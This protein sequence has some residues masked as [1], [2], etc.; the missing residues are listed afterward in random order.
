MIS[1]LLLAWGLLCDT[2]L[3]M[4]LHGPKAVY[5][6]Y[7][8]SQMRRQWD[9]RPPIWAL[10][11]DYRG[12]KSSEN[13]AGV[14][15]DL[16]I[17]VFKNAD[18]LAKLLQTLLDS[19]PLRAQRIIL[20][21]DC[22]NDPSVAHHLTDFLEQEQRAEVISQTSNLGFSGNVTALLTAS[23]ADYV[24]VLN[25]DTLIPPGSLDRLTSHFA[26]DPNLATISPLTNNG[27]YAL[28]ASPPVCKDLKAKTLFDI[29][30]RLAKGPMQRT[31]VPFSSGFCWAINRAIFFE[32]GGFSKAFEA[33]YGEEADFCFRARRGGY[34]VMLAQDCAV[35]HQGS[36]SFGA[37]YARRKSRLNSTLL[38]K[39][40]P[41]YKTVLDQ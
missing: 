5:Q 24:V 19:P 25:T 22:S 35:W 28:L 34:S 30:K 6:R 33:G 41:E 17:P 12:D 8:I 9:N 37:A 39:L 4:W 14:A 26:Q 21:D 3:A 16:V 29:D 20:S 38:V 1:K 2:A 27:A 40:Y 11:Q 13:R 23:S 15:Y 7:Q 31:D 32:L 10:T 18:D 36:G